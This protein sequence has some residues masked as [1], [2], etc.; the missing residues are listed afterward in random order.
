MSTFG[1][2]TSPVICRNGRTDS[3][4]RCNDTSSSSTT[5][6]DATSSRPTAETRWKKAFRRRYGARLVLYPK[7]SVRRHDV[8]AIQDALVDIYLLQRCTAF[9]GTMYSS[10]TDLASV[11]CPAPVYV[12]DVP[13]PRTRS[14]R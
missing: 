4:R 2:R 8:E 3:C 13:R 12:E 9:V 5:G 1:D 7:R 11:Y 6:P 10:F 14:A